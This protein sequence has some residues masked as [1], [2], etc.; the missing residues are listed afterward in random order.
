MSS[1]VNR[2]SFFSQILTSP[3]F[4]KKMKF[5]TPVQITA[6]GWSISPRSRLL[7]VGSC[8]ADNIG[9][10]FIEQQF[11]AEVNPYGTMYN[12]VSVLHSVRRTPFIADVAFLTLGT[13]HV[14]RLRETGEIVDNCAK[15]PAG[16]FN[17][18]EMSVEECTRCLEETL[19]LLSERNS[20]VKVVVT[21]SPIRYAKY[22]F[23]GS[24]L[25]KAVLLLAA[26]DFVRRHSDSCWYFPAYELLLDELRDY[27][28]Y[29]PDMLHPSP[30]AVDYI[31]ERLS[32]VAFSPDTLR[33]IDELR[34]ILA[35]LNHRFFDPQLPESVTFR[36]ETQARFEAFLAKWKQDSGK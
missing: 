17:E 33:Y 29:A 16:L 8:F 35:A 21:V 26:D 14:W 15:R 28:F 10:K 25:S 32:D 6:P 34:P 31:W 1:D 24:R 18:E 27:R 4:Q 7:F 13:N 36:E 5:N 11:T 23:H 3:V 19:A 30:Q 20:E 9:Q 22:G 12:P 2:G